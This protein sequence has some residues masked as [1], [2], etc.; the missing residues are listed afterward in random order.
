MPWG[1][2][3]FA[4]VI[5]INAVNPSVNS[6]PGNGAFIITNPDAPLSLINVPANTNASLISMSWVDGVA[7]GGTPVIDYN[8]MWD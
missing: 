6:L 2:S 8:V 7:N 3:V 1:S 4:K 5:A